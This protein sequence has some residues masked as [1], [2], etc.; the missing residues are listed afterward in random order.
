M[1]AKT[2][3]FTVAVLAVLCTFVALAQTELRNS[4]GPSL[5]NHQDIALA[6][7]SQVYVVIVQIPLRHNDHSLFSHKL[8]AVIASKL[9]EAGID[10]ADSNVTDPNILK[11]LKR[12]FESIE[13][14]EWRRADI[15][16]LRVNMHALDIEE[17]NSRVFYIQTSLARNCFC[18]QTKCSIKAD[19]WKSEPA[20][21]I[22]AADRITEKV[23]EIV[24]HQ[25]DAFI[26][27]WSAAGNIGNQPAGAK[28]IK[29]QSKPDSA[30]DKKAAVQQTAGANFVASKNSR[31]FHK[32]DC[33][34]A[35]L[36]LPENLVTYKTRDDAMKAGKRPCKRCKP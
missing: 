36:I 4:P 8:K 9:K 33:P 29:T 25:T 11:V 34:F 17:H 5:L 13:N 24:L 15:P 19:V 16:E 22:I 31:V 2:H 32:P 1:K 14:L 18:E 3:I 35:E 12:R 21:Q 30:G 6:G 27:C 20:I 28:D 10:V 7:I 23:T 26:T